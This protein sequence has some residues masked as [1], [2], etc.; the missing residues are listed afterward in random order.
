VYFLPL[1]FVVVTVNIIVVS[2]AT[3]PASL[4]QRKTGYDNSFCYCLQDG[5]V[6]EHGTHSEL[7]S[8]KGHYY[9]LVEAQKCCG[10]D[11]E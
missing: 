1:L 3:M 10:G 9:R 6:R 8:M 11:V 4:T 5:A 7:L 2:A